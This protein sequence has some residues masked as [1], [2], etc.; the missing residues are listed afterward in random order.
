MKLILVV[1]LWGSSFGQSPNYPVTLSAYN[2]APLT[3]STP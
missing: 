1:P 2:L 3:P